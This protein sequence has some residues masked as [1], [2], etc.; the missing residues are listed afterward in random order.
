MLFALVS[1]Q[2]RT[3]WVA[4]TL[5]LPLLLLGRWHGA[6]ISGPVVRWSGAPVALL[7][8]AAVALLAWYAPTIVAIFEALLSGSFENVPNTSLGQRIHMWQIG[9]ANWLH[10]PWLGNGPTRKGVWTMTPPCF[11]LAVCCCS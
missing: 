1:S 3:S 8:A 7:T 5:V 10:L 2:S 9:V 11:S 6:R 4:T